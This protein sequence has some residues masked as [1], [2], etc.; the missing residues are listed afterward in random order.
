MPLIP[1]AMDL[2]NITLRAL[3]TAHWHPHRGCYCW[4]L[5]HSIVCA[6]TSYCGCVRVPAPAKSH[7]IA[8]SSRVAAQNS[9]QNEQSALIICTT[10]RI[11]PGAPVEH[12]TSLPSVNT[13]PIHKDV[14]LCNSLLLDGQALGQPEF[15]CLW[16]ERNWEVFGVVLDGV[17]DQPVLALVQVTCLHSAD[18]ISNGWR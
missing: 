16:V 14:N 1:S 9:R 6:I 18:H 3:V 11:Q 7:L 13:S 4:H 5:R 17:A 8:A 2:Q 15:P 10:R 12:S